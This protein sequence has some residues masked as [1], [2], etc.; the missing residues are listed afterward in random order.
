VNHPLCEQLTDF[1]DRALST[2]ERASFTAH[3]LH[4]SSCRHSVQEAE[5][6]ELLLRRAVAASAVPAGLAERAEKRIRASAR[7]RLAAGLAAAAAAVLLA[8]I[9]AWWFGR[10]PQPPPP[11][12][13]RWVENPA[14]PAPPP[15]P[16]E[17][18]PVVRADFAPESSVIAVRM[19]SQSPN[20][21]IIWVYPTATTA[22]RG[23]VSDEPDSISERDRP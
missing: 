22:A 8:G 12:P 17:V 4:C 6:I 5:R 14:P 9:G 16:P 19:P 2:E 21:T 13:P 10:V 20:V 11:E 18:R 15:G 3:L 7:G 23:P 1:L